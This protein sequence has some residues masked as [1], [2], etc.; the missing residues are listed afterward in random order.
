M[1]RRWRAYK[2]LEWFIF[3]GFAM[4]AFVALVAAVMVVMGGRPARVVVVQQRPSVAEIGDYE[5]GFREE[6][7]LFRPG[8]KRYFVNANSILQGHP[9]YA[10][11]YPAD[12]SAQYAEFGEQLLLQD[13]SFRYLMDVT[14]SYDRYFNEVEDSKTVKIIHNEIIN[15]DGYPARYR[16]LDF[17]RQLRVGPGGSSSYYSGQEHY[18]FLHIPKLE[19]VFQFMAKMDLPENTF[20]EIVSSFEILESEGKNHWR[21]YRNEELGFEMQYPSNWKVEIQDNAVIF[22]PPSGDLNYG[23]S[24]QMEDNPQGL[25]LSSWVKNRFNPNQIESST[26]T[27]FQEEKVAGR[28]QVTIEGVGPGAFQFKSLFIAHRGKV[29]GFSYIT[30]LPDKTQVAICEK[31]LQSFVVE[32]K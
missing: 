3:V 12:F 8:W 10:I 13:S 24:V 25:P 16:V 30:N 11:S 4:A 6:A 27:A 5:D 14:F 32:P 29:T 18:V 7:D 9:Q 19:L 31:M 28:D 15:V 22:D 23:C 21:K 1:P 26:L 17:T 2:S 20:K